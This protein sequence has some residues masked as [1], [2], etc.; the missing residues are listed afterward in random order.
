ME[1]AVLEKFRSDLET[2]GITDF[3]LRIEGGNKTI[4]NN[5]N[6]KIILQDDYIIG[7]EIKNNHG[8]SSKNNFNIVAAPYEDIDDAKV[9][10]VTVKQLMDFLT[11]SG[12][13]IDDELKKF[14][15]SHGNRVILQTR[16]EGGYYEEVKNAKG[17]VVF[18]TPLPG[19]VTM[20]YTTDQEGPVQV[21]EDSPVK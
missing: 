15:S 16:T 1:K 12:I 11:A 3:N 6:S 4:A 2:A 14:I 21:D 8:A 20:G 5:E 17:Q 7:I 19:R 9:F 18:T 13:T 10:D